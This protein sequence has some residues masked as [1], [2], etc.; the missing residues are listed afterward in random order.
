MIGNRWRSEQD[1]DDKPRERKLRRTWPQRFLVLF[2]VCMILVALAMAWTLRYTYV[3]AASV[4]RVQLGGS[5]TPRAESSDSD[6]GVFNVLIVG[7]D[8][9]AGLDEDDPI[10]VGRN[11]ERFSDVILIAHVDEVEG[12]ATIMS[13]PRDL[14]LPIAGLDREAKINFA[15]GVGG[16]AV[17]IE[18]IETELDIPINHYV[19]ID[20]AGFQGL[21]EVVGTV[22]VFFELPARDWNARP[23]VGP[24]RTQTGFEIGAGC[25]A[26]DPPTALAYVR[27]RHYQVQMADGSWV[28]STPPSDLGRMQR[29]QDFIRRLIQRAID[30][31]A[32]NPFVL[33]D[34]VDAGLDNVTIDQELTPQTLL[35]VG[36]T[37]RD[38]EPGE[39]QTFSYPTEFGF[40]GS[41]SVLFGLDEPAAPILEIFRGASP[42]DPS[43][44]AISVVTAAGVEDDAG[45]LVDELSD[46][47][48]IVSGPSLSDTEPGIVI[49][50]GADGR[51]A[52]EVVRDRLSSSTIADFVGDDGS[53]RLEEI[54]TLPGRSVIVVVGTASPSLNSTIPD[55]AG[56]GVATSAPD[57]DSGTG[58]EASSDAQVTTTSSTDPS[59][60][61]SGD[62]PAED[63]DLAPPLDASGCG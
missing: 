44:V 21:V 8:S 58:E 63:A 48:F 59:T 28:D 30:L 41:S 39:L 9:D 23:A 3:Q 25:H 45:D 36:R 16:P 12:T 13:V 18:T 24:P 1:G 15:F 51:Q 5:L 2:N 26:L 14:W 37:F 32:R 31:G 55:D 56:V 54:D 22:D 42:S 47:G 11:G 4:E 62:Q 33:S 7:Y 38:F 20:F 57:S 35:D 17:L 50:H 6:G 10:R 43:T 27:S 46:A 40:V 53:V 49:R 60:P 61:S 19:A 52:A 34:L 29:Q